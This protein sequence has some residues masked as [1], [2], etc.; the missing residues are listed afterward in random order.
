VASEIG[1]QA[2]RTALSWRRTG[3]SL[4]ALAALTVK[5]MIASTS[6]ALLVAA[7]LLAL[8]MGLVALHERRLRQRAG[9][10]LVAEAPVIASVV[11]LT[12]GCV[13]VALLAVLGIVLS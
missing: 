5:A 6:V 10:E 7:V 12:V 1:V 3:L 4:A 8:A 11:G 13:A 2:E 9:R